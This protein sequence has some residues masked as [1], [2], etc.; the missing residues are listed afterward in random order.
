MWW[1]LII[2]VL[3]PTFTDAATW[4]VRPADDGNGTDLKYGAADGTSY[5]SA[6]DGFA[7]I[8]GIAAGDTVCLPGSDEPFFERLD[9]GT[10]GVIYKGCRATHAKLWSAQ[11]LSGNRSFNASRVLVDTAAYAWSRTAAGLWKKRIDIRPHMLWE[12]TT[13]L[14]PVDIDAL[15]EEEAGALLKVGQWGVR[16]S[17][18]STYSILYRPTVTRNTPQ[19]TVIRC[20]HIPNSDG[21]PA[22]MVTVK[23][24]QT[25]QNIDVWGYGSVRSLTYPLLIDTS[26]GVTL[27][28]MV[29][30]RNKRGPG[31]GNEAVHSTISNVTLTNVSVLHSEATGL[32]ITPGIRL[33]NLTVP[34]GSFSYTSDRVYDGKSI[35]TTADGDGIGIGYTGGTGSNFVFKGITVSGNANVG[36]F[37]GT[38]SPLTVTNLAITGWVADRN[39]NGCFKEDTQHVRGLFT[40]A[41]FLCVNTP[42]GVAIDPVVVGMNGPPG[43]ARTVTIANGTFSRNSTRSQLR[44]TPYA[45][46]THRIVNNVFT[47]NAASVNGDRGDIYILGGLMVGGETIA[48][49]YFYSRPGTHTHFSLIGTTQHYYYDDVSAARFNTDTGSTNSFLNVNPLLTSAFKPMAGS[50]LRRAGTSYGACTDARGRRCLDVPDIGAYQSTSGDISS[51]RGASTQRMAAPP[52]ARRL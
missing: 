5:A 45:N 18:G 26:N 42:D 43:G 14:E 29:F 4:H 20:D 7:S 38:V 37:Y 52:R 47:S 9:A 8:A 36:I 12:D 24:R 16:D 6:F 46:T 32:S 13:W 28:N 17:G 15:S 34:G 3:V 27:K 21:T 50:P 40:I 41:G 51:A 2:C 30:Y 19:T 22:H 31:I 49:N 11:G 44:I 23:D 35:S 48:N 33:T 25:F 1:L 10:V 39:T